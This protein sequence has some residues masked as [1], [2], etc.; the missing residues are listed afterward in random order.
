MIQKSDTRTSAA[1]C[2]CGHR[3]FNGPH[4]ACLRGVQGTERI[5]RSFACAVQLSIN[6]F[7]PVDP[8]V[9][10]KLWD[11]A[12]E[13]PKRA[14]AA[15]ADTDEEEDTDAGGDASAAADDEE[16]FASA[17]SSARQGLVAGAEGAARAVDQ[18]QAL[19]AA[20]APPDAAKTV[21][22]V[23][24]GAS[25]QRP[26]GSPEA[27][28]E[29]TRDGGTYVGPSFPAPLRSVLRDAARRDAAAAMMVPVNVRWALPWRRGAHRRRV[30]LLSALLLPD[31]TVRVP[32]AMARASRNTD[33]TTGAPLP[34][35]RGVVYV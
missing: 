32:P 22:F 2:S 6:A 18:L 21:R 10:A 7:T 23:R 25:A 12:R 33:C 3:K 13:V 34:R 5:V 16:A 15:D 11:V 9:R 17:M 30:A 8:S 31:R 26:G 1:R 24:L 29:I 35:E 20:V 14:G 28:E 27:G 4:G 19:V